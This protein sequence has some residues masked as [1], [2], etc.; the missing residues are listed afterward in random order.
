MLF[1]TVQRSSENLP[2]D[3][4]AFGLTRF[5]YRHILYMAAF[6]CRNRGRLFVQEPK[7]AHIDPGEE[8]TNVL[9]ELALILIIQAHHAKG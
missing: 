9:D 1:E 6:L 4:A 8:R 7:S 5:V 2:I 3:F